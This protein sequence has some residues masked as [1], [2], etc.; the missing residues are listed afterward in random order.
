MVRPPFWWSLLGLFIVTHNAP[1]SSNKG[2]LNDISTRCEVRSP[3]DIILYWKQTKPRQNKNVTLCP[4]DQ[5]DQSD[6]SCLKGE[7]IPSDEVKSESAF[8]FT[9]FNQSS[10]YK[11]IIVYDLNNTTFNETVEVDIDKCWQTGLL[12]DSNVRCELRGPVRLTLRWKQNVMTLQE[13]VYLCLDDHI[14]NDCIKGKQITYDGT[15][16]ESINHF[17]NVQPNATYKAVLTSLLEDKTFYNKTTDIDIDKC[18][19]QGCKTGEHFD[20]NFFCNGSGHRHCKKEMIVNGACL[21]HHHI[22]VRGESSVLITLH[23]HENVDS[24]YKLNTSHHASINKTKNGC[25]V[26]FTGLMPGE[27]VKVQMMLNTLIDNDTKALQYTRKAYSMP[28]A[29]SDLQGRCTRPDNVRLTWNQTGFCAKT[30]CRV[31]P[32]LGPKD[33]CVSVKGPNCGGAGVKELTCDLNVQPNANYTAIVEIDN[34]S[35][36]KVTTE[37]TVSCS[38]TSTPEAPINLKG[39]CDSQGNITV[40]WN[41][42]G[43]CTET[44]CRLCP[45]R[46]PDTCVSLHGPSCSDSGTKELSCTVNLPHGVVYNAFVEI[47]GGGVKTNSSTRVSCCGTQVPGA[48]TNLQGHCNSQGDVNLTWSQTGLCTRTTCRLCPIPKTEDKC[49][50]IDRPGCGNT[51]AEEKSC[52][53]K[54]RTNTKYTADVALEFTTGCQTKVQTTVNCHS[55]SVPAPPDGFRST[56]KAPGEIKLEWTQQGPIAQSVCKLCPIGKPGNFCL[57]VTGPNSPNNGTTNGLN[58]NFTLQQDVKYTFVVEVSNSDSEK[59]AG[60]GNIEYYFNSE[61][62]RNASVTGAG[63]RSVNVSMKASCLAMRGDV[64]YVVVNISNSRCLVFGTSHTKCK[65]ENRQLLSACERQPDIP[66]D[67]CEGDEDRDFILPVSGLTPYTTYTLLLVPW[68]CGYN[69]GNT[70]NSFI[71]ETTTDPLEPWT[72]TIENVTWSANIVTIIWPLPNLDPGPV[73]YTLH[74]TDAIQ[75]PSGVENTTTV[76]STPHKTWFRRVSCTVPATRKTTK[77]HCSA[78]VPYAFWNYKVAV[79]VMTAKGNLAS[80]ATNVESTPQTPG[81][82]AALHVSTKNMSDLTTLCGHVTWTEYS[83]VCVM[84]KETCPHQRDNFIHGYLYRLTPDDSGSTPQVIPSLLLT[85]GNDAVRMRSDWNE[86]SYFKLLSVATDTNY[87][88]CVRSVGPS[89]NITGTESCTKFYLP[90]IK[91]SLSRGDQ[92]KVEK[93]DIPRQNDSNRVTFTMKS[94]CFMVKSTY[95]NITDNGLIISKGPLKQDV[96]FAKL[97]S[98]FERDKFGY[99]KTKPDYLNSQSNCNTSRSV[100]VGNDVCSPGDNRP[101]KYC[102]GPL[103]PGTKYS[104]N[105]MVCTNAGCSS[106]PVVDNISTPGPWNVTIEN[107]TW[108]NNTVTITWPLPDL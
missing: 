87:T 105:A 108:S 29:P 88:F 42:T 102:D 58:C 54:V 10:V 13:H 73:T 94:T 66:T 74:I 26:N 60:T 86:T 89:P 77:G 45:V 21:V 57:S 64:R 83:D 49:I 19:K 82:V 97:P 53:M 44:V 18:L 99:Y 46:E 72:V 20:H 15:K 79:A 36:E 85:H 51:G 16:K 50:V 32:A 48:L 38:S 27:E 31:C 92:Y 93:K 23:V 14:I 95:G 100:V 78:S 43:L 61:P 81:P 22:N 98:W 11:A 24:D 6:D 25:D 107:V 80:H 5:S 106:T 8:F 35:G 40:M 96:D 70:N 101:G 62:V 63:T 55:A 65:Q 52:N 84:W 75:A 17:E 3:V 37:T 28:A 104:I 41:Q 34:G 71:L 103:D 1:V 90:A 7:L 91:P 2:S 39:H 33:T 30:H 12:Q 56:W 47:H 59:A 4:S 68:Y 67:V 76:C 69:H 9:I